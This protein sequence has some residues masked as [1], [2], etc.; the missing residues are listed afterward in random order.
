MVKVTV[1]CNGRVVTREGKLAVVAVTSD[2]GDK[3]AYEQIVQGYGALHLSAAMMG[4]AEHMPQVLTEHT[5][6]LLWAAV[7]LAEISAQ[8]ERITKKY[9]HELLEKAKEGQT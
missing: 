3:V 5:T 1:E 6:S 7:N 8:T 2:E 9:I 4:L